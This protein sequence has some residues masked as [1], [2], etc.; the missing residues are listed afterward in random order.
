MPSAA[1]GEWFLV[2]K[3]SVKTRRKRFPLEAELI[4]V[5]PFLTA[6]D[7]KFFNGVRC[8]TL[9]LYAASSAVNFFCAF[10]LRGDQSLFFWHCGISPPCPPSMGE[11]VFP[12]IFA[13]FYYNA[14]KFSFSKTM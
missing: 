13:V 9:R 14:I 6:E 3:L 7:A 12:G 10:E 4:V 11:S 1:G 5:V 8:A 2:L